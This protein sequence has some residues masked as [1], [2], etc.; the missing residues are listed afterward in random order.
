[1][2]N[3]IF[4]SVYKCNNNN[5]FFNNYHNYKFSYLDKKKKSYY[6]KLSCT[7]HGL[8]ISTLLT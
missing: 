2:S 3:T 6:V 4:Y 1:M 5:F 8:P 7:L